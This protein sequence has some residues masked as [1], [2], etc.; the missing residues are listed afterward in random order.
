MWILPSSLFLWGCSLLEPNHQA[1]REPKLAH[2]VRWHRKELRPLT[3]TSI[4]GQ[5]CEWMKLE[6]IPAL[7]PN[8]HLW[9]FWDHRHGRTHI[10]C[11]CYA[12]S[13]FRTLRIHEHNKLSLYTTYIIC[14]IAIVTE[15]A[16]KFTA[17]HVSPGQLTPSLNP[18][19]KFLGERYW[20]DLVWIPDSH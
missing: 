19:F 9:I 13:K 20:L 17:R 16:P 1:V 10:S 11:S 2:V 14:S 5:T 12:L 6:I 7:L 3:D 18:N 15:T 4:N 8:T